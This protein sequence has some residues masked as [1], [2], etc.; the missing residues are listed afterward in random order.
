MDIGRQTSA[1]GGTGASDVFQLLRDGA[2]RSRTELAAMTGMARSTIGDRLDVLAALGLI[3]PSSDGTS[4]GGRPPRRVALIPDARLV[5]AVDLGASHARLALVNLLNEQL[6]HHEETLEISS[7]PEATLAEVMRIADDLLDTAGRGREEIMAVGIGLPG[8]VHF[9]TGRPSRPPIMPG[10]DGFDV[11]AWFRDH[12]DALVLVDN[13]VNIM[14]LG[15]HSML[16]RPAEHFLFV[17]VATGIGAGIISSGRLQRGAQG[18]A[19]DIGHVRV[20]TGDG[21]FC[22]CGNEGCLEAVASGSAVARKLREQ[23]FEEATTSGDVV[24][25]ADAGHL[26]AI[27]AVRLAGRDL[28]EVLSASI[29]FL[30]PEVIAVGG[31]MAAAG[32][33]LLAGVREVVYQRA[34]PLAT[35]GLDIH[36]AV[37]SR[38]AGLLGASLLALHEALS[39]TGVEAMARGAATP[40]A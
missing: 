18:I 29:S 40:A 37:M 27:Q 34:M 38:E 30:N 24:R 33:H 23:G 6:A 8:P 32:E 7:G 1:L 31:R 19:G 14:A 17:K 15:E 35:Q 22:H 13:D 21:I 4:T 5:L 9:E 28:G 26:P 11:P 16:S 12:L 10:W 36:P 20:P 39:P 2:P 25:L 3:G